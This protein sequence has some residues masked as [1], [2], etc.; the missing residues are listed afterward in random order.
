MASF[1]EML[2]PFRK[3]DCCRIFHE[4]ILIGCDFHGVDSLSRNGA[5]L[6]LLKL[7]PM[8][9]F[10]P[11]RGREENAEKLSSSGTVGGCARD[12]EAG[13]FV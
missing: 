13:L 9:S 10:S 5:Q 11:K 2:P 1:G 4:N 8:R 6:G 7:A 12:S 3:T